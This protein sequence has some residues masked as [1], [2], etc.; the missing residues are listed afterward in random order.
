MACFSFQGAKLL[1]TGE[2]G[3]LLTDDDALYER[4]KT[5]ADQGRD[6]SRTFWIQE[7]GWK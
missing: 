2:G 6:P 7:L 5:I 3:M 1:V 4:A